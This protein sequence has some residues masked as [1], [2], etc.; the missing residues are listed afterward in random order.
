MKVVSLCFMVVFTMAFPILAVPLN[1]FGIIF[2]KGKIRKCYGL[3]LAISLAVMAYIW[4]PNQATDLYRHHQELGFLTDFDVGQLGVYVK[5]SLEPVQY[6]VKFIVAQ[7]GNFN[8]LQFLVILCGYFELFW[9]ISDFAELKNIKNSRFLLLLVYAFTS[10]RFINFASGLWCN[11]AIINIAVG[12]YL[13]FFKK[14]KYL[15]YLFYILAAALHIGS[16]YVVFLVL[17]LKNMKMFRKV[18]FSVLITMFLIISSFGGIVLVINNIFGT[19]FALV[20]MLNRLYDGYFVNGDQF[21][22]LHTGWNLALPLINMLIC[23]LLGFRHLNKKNMEGYDSFLVYLSVCIL[24]TLINAGVFVRYGFLMAILA[25]PLIN[26]F[27]EETKNKRLIF[28]LTVM[29]L[30]MSSLQFYRSCSQ[31]NSVGLDRQ[32][33]S[34][35]AN[36]I[37]Y[38]MEGE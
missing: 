3:L 22:S 33:T 38:I 4:V 5:S 17:F 15:Q 2:F 30:S 20:T 32:I 35:V 21:E 34:N 31:I 12:V 7:T 26:N 6:L 18:R 14:T 10:V 37:F 24:A 29:I 28:L 27:L 25:L 19:D 13:E 23:L 36:N 11:F 1:L 16:L 9:L 8:L